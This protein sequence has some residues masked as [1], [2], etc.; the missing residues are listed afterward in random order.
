MRTSRST[1]LVTALYVLFAFAGCRNDGLTS[2]SPTP[3]ATPV[4]VETSV[5]PP[6][7]PA[8]PEPTGHTDIKIKPD[9]TIVISSESTYTACVYDDAVD[10]D[11]PLLTSYKVHQGS[12]PLLFTNETCEP[13][14]LQ[15]DVLGTDTCPQ[16]AG[17]FEQYL[18]GLRI[19]LPS[20][21]SP[22]E[23]VECEDTEPTLISTEIIKEGKWSEC[24]PLIPTRPSTSTVVSQC[25]RSRDITYEL[26]YQLCDTL[27]TETVTRPVREECACEC[28]EECVLPEEGLTLS[29]R[30][31]GDPQTECRAFGE[32]NAVRTGADF[33]I[34]K[35][36]TDREVM[37]SPPTGETCSNGKDISHITKCACPPE[38]D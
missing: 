14:K 21:L 20:S 32:Y 17:P 18:G 1:V 34:C 23:C 3:E 4:L 2:P 10:W 37:Y 38:D 16:K 35:A 5:T 29:W 6:P 22:E 15:V 24:E 31:A 28:E 13:L 36:G 30:G 11:Q 19:L 27:W 25:F 26:T 12:N 9:G 8:S 7:A 33:Y